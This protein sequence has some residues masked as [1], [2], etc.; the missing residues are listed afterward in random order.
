MLTTVGAEASRRWLAIL[1]LP[2]IPKWHAEIALCHGTTTF[3]LNIY[4]EEW[5][6]AFRHRDRMSWIRV[7]DV[8]FVHGRDEFKLLPQTP[9]LLAIG[10]TIA[11]LERAHDVPLRQGQP[12]IRTNV[13]YAT[14]VIRDWIR[15]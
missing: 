13:P 7:T 14:E 6:F 8:P 9:G 2:A 15:K 12:Q 3:E 4:P 10:K 1:A 11:D 5:G